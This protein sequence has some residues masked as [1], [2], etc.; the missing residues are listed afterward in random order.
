MVLLDQEITNTL[1]NGQVVCMCAICTGSQ[2]TRHNL[3]DVRAHYRAVTHVDPS[4]NAR[5]IYPAYEQSGHTMQDF[6]RVLGGLVCPFTDTATPF[7][8]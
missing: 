6:M 2:V 7:V 4:T 5:V 1:S 3:P 8:E